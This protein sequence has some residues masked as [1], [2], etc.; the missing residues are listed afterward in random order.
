M[1]HADD[2]QAL[3]LLADESEV[4]SRARA[5]EQVRLLWEVCQIPDFR[6]V[7][8]EAHARLLREIFL[9]LSASRRRLPEDWVSKQVTALDR[10]D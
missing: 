8:S 5:I 4:R 6:N 9:H 3:R 2:H 10:I 7:L 1:R